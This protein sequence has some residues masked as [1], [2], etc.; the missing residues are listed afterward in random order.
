MVIMDDGKNYLD[1]GGVWVESDA[2][3]IAQQVHDYDDN[4]E[5]IVLDP[6]RPG[7]KITS[8]PFMVVQR[9]PNGTYQ[10]VLEAWE[11]D[12]RIM[13]RIWLS[14]QHR[15]NQLQTLEQMEKAIKEGIDK[16]YR[17]KM[18]EANELSID[19]IASKASSYTF[20][21]KEG[22]K[23]KIHENNPNASRNNDKKSF[24]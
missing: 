3:R 5:V 6:D 20:K 14:D 23:V 17:E 2:L 1:M 15:N 12:E 10:K 21:N 4:L 7:I 11:L 8:A 18:D 9:M 24:S 19:I 22:D 13:E 16:R